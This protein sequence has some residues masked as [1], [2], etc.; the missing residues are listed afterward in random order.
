MYS[1]SDWK[2]FNVVELCESFSSWFFWWNPDINEDIFLSCRNIWQNI[3]R[4]SRF[5][6]VNWI[7]F[8]LSSFFWGWGGGGRGGS[9]C[10]EWTHTCGFWD[11]RMMTHV[12]HQHKMSHVCLLGKWAIW[13]LIV[14]GRKLEFADRRQNMGKCNWNN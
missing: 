7:A 4:V 14:F 6:S 1:L 3:F 9:K 12:W 5:K 8:N 13:I 11:Q 2:H 10:A